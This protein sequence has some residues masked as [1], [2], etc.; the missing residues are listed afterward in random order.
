ML[1]EKKKELLREFVQRRC[2]ECGRHEK[3]VGKLQPHRIKPGGEYNL[4][5]IKMVCGYKGKIGGKYSCH[6]IFSSAQR[7]ANGIQS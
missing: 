7:I 3:Q 2:E 4:R 1:S 6:S 5:N